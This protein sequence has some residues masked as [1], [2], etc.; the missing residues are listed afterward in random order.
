MSARSAEKQREQRVIIGALAVLVLSLLLVYGVLPLVRQVS[1]REMQIDA[2]RSRAALLA[3]YAAAAPRLEQAAAHDEAWLATTARRVLHATSEP[4]AASALQSLLQDAAEGAGMAVNRVEVNPDTD[5]ASTGG[6]VAQLRGSISAY[7]DIHGV[8]ALL[9]TL[10]AG[11]RVVMVE[12]FSVQQNS[13]LRGAPDVLQVTIGVRA[14]VL[15]D[16]ALR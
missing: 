7:G 15:I 10:E 8:S 16:G 2:A 13:A 3:G 12:R 5:S 11:P 4:I 9:R 14:P 1:A 6:T